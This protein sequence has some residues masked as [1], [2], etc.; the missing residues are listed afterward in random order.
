MICSLYRD[1]A[2]IEKNLYKHSEEENLEELKVLLGNIQ[3]NEDGYYKPICLFYYNSIRWKENSTLQPKIN[4]ASQL[5]QKYIEEYIE[6]RTTKN[7]RDEYHVPAS[8]KELINN[9]LRI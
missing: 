4:E 2:R 8:L 6:D 5:L 7:I 1:I 9:I 3:K